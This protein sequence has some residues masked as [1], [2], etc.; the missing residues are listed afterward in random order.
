M[1][2]I[3]VHKCNGQVEVAIRRFKRLCD[4]LG[5][6]KRMRE[7]EHHVKKTTIRRRNKAAAVKR[8]MKRLSKERSLILGR[9]R[10]KH[11]EH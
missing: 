5:L 7:L 9:R 1:P 11:T 4:K 8:H 3:D 10:S 6:P 2:S